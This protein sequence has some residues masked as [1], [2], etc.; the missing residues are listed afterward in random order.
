[1]SFSATA[2][3]L[4]IAAAPVSGDGTMPATLLAAAPVTLAV[5]PVA[6]LDDDSA[7]PPP[8]AAPA[9]V[10]TEPPPPAP[11][12]VPDDAQTVDASQD[13]T[14]SAT[15][16]ETPGD[17]LE[18]LNAQ[19]Y[20]VVQAADKAFVEP[21]AK[22]YEKVLP[23]PVRSGLRNF[24]RNLEAP[25]VAVNFLLQGK[26][27]S[28][29]ETVGRFAVNTTVGVGGLFDVAKDKPFNLPYRP[30]GFA[31]TLGYYGV[32]PGP[33]MY[34]PLIGPTTVRDLVGV[35]LDRGF[36]PA[37]VGKPLSDPKTGVGVAVVRSLDYRVEFD[38]ILKQNNREAEDPYAATRTYYLEMRQAEIDALKGKKPVAEATAA[39]APV[40]EAIAVPEAV[41]P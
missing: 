30:N 28:A 23:K 3:A 15:L 39:P 6:V 26:P 5:D 25:V 37:L 27:V 8:E 18:K 20:A 35:T 24:L 29:L 10:A 21:V 7:A 36:V 41:Q 19:S 32:G 14:V 4:L 1:M 17:P 33:Y 13:I 38:D 2:S 11:P 22:A 9:P 12:P 34:L 40:T 31:N 16:P